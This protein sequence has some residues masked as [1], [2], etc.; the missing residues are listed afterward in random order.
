[1]N[2]F[3]RVD[4]QTFYRFAAEHA[5]QRYEFV[6]GRIVQQMTG[7]T[8]D[9]GQVGRRITRLIEDQLDEA[10][11]A[12]LPD[13]GVE[14]PET[15][16]YPDIVVEPAEEPGAS[17]STMRPVLV[18]EVL[19][20]STTATDLDVKPEEYMGLSSLDVYIVASQHEPACLVWERGADGQ[21][22]T[23]R[24]VRGHAASINIAGRGF[25][26]VLPLAVIYRGIE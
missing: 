20:P 19:S 14:T 21:F 3:A 1:M 24:E 9:H 18:V 7:G 2:A 26:L 25:S 16:R 22:S 13:R 5:E 11:W 6:R 8:R 15:I 4:K 10:R 17:L 23:P 12:V